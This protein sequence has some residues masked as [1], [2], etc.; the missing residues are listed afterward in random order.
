MQSAPSVQSFA[1][2]RFPTLT[3]S[4]NFHIFFCPAIF[5]RPPAGKLASVRRPSTV[6]GQQSPG[7][8]AARR[9]PGL[10]HPTDDRRQRSDKQEDERQAG[11]QHRHP[12]G[13][14]TALHV[15][16]SISF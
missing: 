13:S 3:I 6:R 7:Q 5:R 9:R 11:T 15:S 8:P 12:G 4:N 10:R 16:G 2:Y 14:R 1:E